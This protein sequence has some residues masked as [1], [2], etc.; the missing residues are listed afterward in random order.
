MKPC[1]GIEIRKLKHTVEAERC[2][3]MMA[4]SKPWATLRQNY[5]AWLE[6][7]S[8][9]SREVYLAFVDG[10]ITGF[11]ILH[12]QGILNGYIQSVC[13]AAEWRNKGIGSRLM[14]FAERRIF[15]KTQN[16][17]ICVSTFNHGARRLYERLGYE[18]MGEP[19]DSEILLRKT[20]TSKREEHVDRSNR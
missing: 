8:D 3:R 9:P 19:W 5:T 6:I 4:N 14:T 1:P 11:I 18:I 12:L 2:A 13:V 16:V 20:M 17:F 15:S 10:E 7:V